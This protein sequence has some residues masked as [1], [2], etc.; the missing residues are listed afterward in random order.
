LQLICTK[1]SGE[2]FGEQ[3]IKSASSSRK[4][5]FARLTRK[6][7]TADEIRQYLTYYYKTYT[8]SVIAHLL[9]YTKSLFKFVIWEFIIPIKLCTYVNIG[10]DC[11][12][13]KY[14]VLGK[15]IINQMKFLLL[16]PIKLLLNK[17]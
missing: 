10:D 8:C 17:I 13:L 14:E 16:A 1:K 2:Y 15:I 9:Y 7:A 5:G 12:H 4:E 6:R 11:T 3:E